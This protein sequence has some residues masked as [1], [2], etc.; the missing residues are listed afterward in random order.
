[1]AN[2][3]PLSDNKKPF[4][5]ADGSISFY[6]IDYKEGYHAKSIGAYTESL[7]KFVIP[8]E[9]GKKCNEKHSIWLLD[10]FF[11]LGYNIATTIEFLE[12][13][14]IKSQIN[15]VSIEKD[16]SLIK[17]I[18]TY[19]IL[20]PKKGYSILKKLIDNKSY[21]NYN[22]F[23]I[24]DDFYRAIKYINCKFDII[25]FD[26]FSISKNPEMWQI[27]V[28]KKLY[29]ILD[30]DGCIVTYSCRDKVRKDFYKVGLIPYE[31]KKLP[32]A[33]QPGTVFYKRLRL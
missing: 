30:E 33:F 25:Y 5:T 14:N 7:H 12:R 9:I 8:S 28:Y 20:W 32:D 2:L 11:G 17:L 18:K 24:I 1:M 23:L 3:V 19:N 22:L 4:A 10:I 15:I 6:N 29:E 31:T 26:P 21:K 13:K 27:P 16:E